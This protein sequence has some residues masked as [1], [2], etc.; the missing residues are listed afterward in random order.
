[1]QEVVTGPFYPGTINRSS[2]DSLVLALS[3]NGSSYYVENMLPW[4]YKLAAMPY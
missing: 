3:N 4:E 2:I 1:M